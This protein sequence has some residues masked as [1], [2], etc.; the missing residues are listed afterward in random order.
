MAYFDSPKNRAMWERT[1]AGLRAERERRKATGYAPVSGEEGKAPEPAN[2]YRRRISL[3]ELEE[4][5]RQSEGIRRVPRPTRQ[6]QAG[7][8]EAQEEKRLSQR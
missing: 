6:A 7:M 2:P 5:E 8:Q 1:L 4:I 3:S